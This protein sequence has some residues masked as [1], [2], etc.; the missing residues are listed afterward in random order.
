MLFTDADDESEVVVVS[1]DWYPESE[2]MVVS[3]WVDWE[4]SVF[5]CWVSAFVFIRVR[6]WLRKLTDLRR[7]EVSPSKQA[8]KTYEV[9]SG[10]LYT[11]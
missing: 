11:F 6:K 3:V 7:S 4:M 5:G 10:S 2:F 9:R 1:V 8:T